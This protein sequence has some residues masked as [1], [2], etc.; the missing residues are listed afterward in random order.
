MSRKSK[1]NFLN[2]VSF[3]LTI[4]FAAIFTMFCFA[5]FIA[6]YLM[7]K[8]SLNKEIDEAIA[9]EM[10]EMEILYNEGGVAKLKKEMENEAAPAGIDKEFFLILS[11]NSKVIASTDLQFWPG[12]KPIRSEVNKATKENCL[13]MTSKIPCHKHKVRIGTQKVSDDIV[14][15]LG[16]SFADNNKLLTIFSD[17][18][19]VCFLILIILSIALGWFITKRAMNGVVL[20]TQAAA[21]IKEGDFSHRVNVERKR[22]E[23]VELATVFNQMIDKIEMLVNE[24]KNVANNIAHDLKTPVTRIRGVVETTLTG[25]ESIGNYREMSSVIIEECDSMTSLINTVLDISEADTNM[26]DFKIEDIDLCSI[27]KKAYELFKPVADNKK[28]DFQM[29]YSSNNI[30]LKGN[31]MKLQRVIANLID[32]AI[33]YTP[34]DGQV[35]I[36]LYIDE[37]SACF[38]IQNSGKGISPENIKYIFN[39]FYRCD[40]SRSKLGNGLG[41]SLAT[42]IVKAHGGTI[43]VESEVNKTTTFIVTLPLSLA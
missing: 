13:L 41:L 22:S 28:I 36:N 37:K 7:T 42:A 24:L 33:K 1:N 16:I 15:Q 10:M 14:V 21:K 39:R 3:R 5:A 9:E 20:V 38:K 8:H 19:G 18:I 30:I 6:T 23:I 25:N 34:N 12:L 4:W 27:V 31:S 17:I 32:N 35:S 26:I 43:S 2:S 29:D 40:E 11:T